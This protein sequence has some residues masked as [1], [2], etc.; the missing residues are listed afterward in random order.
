MQSAM[1]SS[2]PPVHEGRCLTRHVQLWQGKLEAKRPC[3]RD[4]GRL[5]KFQLV[6]S[7][8]NIPQE[9]LRPG[10][11]TQTRFGLSPP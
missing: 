11:A 1:S 5:L 7:K 6:I 10:T 2:E 3:Y 9:A 4:G 8:K